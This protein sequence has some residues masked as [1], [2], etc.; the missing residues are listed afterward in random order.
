M[1]KLCKVCGEEKDVNEFRKWSNQCKSCITKHKKQYDENHKEQYKEH[2]EKNKE[3]YI[4]KAKAWVEKNKDRYKEINKKCRT[5][6]KEK[7]AEKRKQYKAANK[8]KIN[9][10]RR[11]YRA[12]KYQTDPLFCLEVLVRGLTRKA[13]TRKGYKKNSKTQQLLGCSF[14]ELLQHLGPKPEGEYHID[15]ICR[16]S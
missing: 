4:A 13:Y 5:K 2:Y 8:D 12:R 6:N 11:E 15:H 14:E 1:L 16:I 3:I 9:E 10:Q 7:Y